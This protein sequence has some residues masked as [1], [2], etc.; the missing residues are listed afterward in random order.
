MRVIIQRVKHASVTVSGE[1]VGKIGKGLLIFI[2]FET[3]D[4]FEDFEWMA[5]KILQMRIFPDRKS[6]V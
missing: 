6:V 3:E 2:G 5:N 4:S 1:I